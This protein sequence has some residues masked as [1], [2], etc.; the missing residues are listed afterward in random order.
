MADLL[1]PVCTHRFDEG[2]ERCPQCGCPRPG[3]MPEYMKL[4]WERAATYI[5][6]ISAVLLVCLLL[7]A[8]RQTAEPSSATNPSTPEAVSSRS[9]EGGAPKEASPPNNSGKDLTASWN[10][11]INTSIDSLIIR[12]E[13]KNATASSIKG[14]QLVGTLRTADGTFISSD[15]GYTSYDTILPGQTSPFEIHMSFNP[16]ARSADLSLKNQDGEMVEFSGPHSETCT[17]SRADL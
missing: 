8:P 14:L 15:D 16:A 1:C 7:F 17:Q 13:V 12:G 9:S 3:V 2:A 5:G 6:S 10:C 11:T 4:P